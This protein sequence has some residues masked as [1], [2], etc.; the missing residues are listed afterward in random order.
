MF[1]SRMLNE[2]TRMKESIQN[3]Y[4]SLIFMLTGGLV[5]KT[6]WKEEFNL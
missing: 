4:F 5:R 1:G 3:I 2:K 6:I